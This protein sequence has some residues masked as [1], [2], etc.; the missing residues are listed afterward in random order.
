MNKTKEKKINAIK[1][2]ILEIKDFVTSNINDDNSEILDLNNKTVK[3]PN[4]TLTLRNIIDYEKN[5]DNNSTYIILDK[6]KNLKMSSDNLTLKKLSQEVYSDKRLDE[7]EKCVVLYQ[8]FTYVGN[9]IYDENINNYPGK[10]ERKA[11]ENFIIK[12]SSVIEYN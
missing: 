6:R 1:S 3:D 8:M 5:E 9:D 12:N 4:D 2:E 7:I 11:S 10:C